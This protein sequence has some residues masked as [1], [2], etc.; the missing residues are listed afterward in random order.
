MKRSSSRYSDRAGF[1]LL[2]LLFVVFI[3][4]VL[5]FYAIVS[6][7]RMRPKFQLTGAAQELAVA[8]QR[9]RMVAIRQQRPVRVFVQ[10]TFE[11]SADGW[12]L[13]YNPTGIK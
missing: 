12:E 6:L 11:A 5:L 9:A 3:A 7:E 1:T 13:P 4:G 8:L 2:E 10:N